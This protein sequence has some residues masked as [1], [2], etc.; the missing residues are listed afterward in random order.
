MAVQKNKVTRS[1]RDM[2]RSH[3]SLKAAAISEDQ[4][5]GELHLRHNVTPDGY[6][7]GKKVV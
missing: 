1:K 2:R 4:T 3:D 5:T 7:K 6:Y